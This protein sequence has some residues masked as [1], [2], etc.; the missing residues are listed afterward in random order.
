MIT[1]QWRRRKPRRENTSCATRVG[2][3]RPDAGNS[4]T[5]CRQALIL[6]D[7]LVLSAFT[8]RECLGTPPGQVEKGDARK[9]LMGTM[10][11]V[12]LT[13]LSL[14]LSRKEEVMSPGE[15]HFDLA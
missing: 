9:Q 11:G 2:Q 8:N 5:P 10:L 15:A 3:H 4:G 1:A 13:L 12:F 7:K 6:N 14:G